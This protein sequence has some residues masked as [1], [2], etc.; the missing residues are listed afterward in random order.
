MRRHGP[1]IAHCADLEDFPRVILTV[2]ARVSRVSVMVSVR[3]SI[4]LNISCTFYYVPDSKERFKPIV[5]LG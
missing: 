5:W 2:T 3:D 4:S 1:V